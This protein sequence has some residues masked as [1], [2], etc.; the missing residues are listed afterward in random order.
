MFDIEKL[1]SFAQD[2]IRDFAAQHQDETFYA[3]C[4]TGS[5]LSL[6][7]EEAFAKTLAYYQEKY[8]DGIRDGYREEKDIQGLKAN[9]GDWQYQRFAVFTEKDGFDE[10]LHEKHYNLHFPLPGGETIPTEY[11]SVMDEVMK[12]LVQ[13][14]AFGGLKRTDGFTVSREEYD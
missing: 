13:K 7:S 3:F 2:A 5:S 10:A 8:P 12:R 1:C 11:G 9:S 6:N 14:D 4:I